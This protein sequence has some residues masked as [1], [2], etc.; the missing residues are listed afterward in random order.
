MGQDFV[1]QDVVGAISLG[2]EVSGAGGSGAGSRESFQTNCTTRHCS[3]K[4]I[5]CLTEKF[6]ED[7][8]ISRNSCFAWPPYSTDLNPC[9]YYLWGYLKSKVYCD[10]YPVTTEQLK[11]NIVRECRRIKKETVQAVIN[12]FNSRIQFILTKKGS[13]FE[14]I[15]NY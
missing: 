7:R 6:D 10:S 9:D 11:K 14:Q 5:E 1:G 4:A 15:L 8:L 13:W 2:Q 12:N 3:K